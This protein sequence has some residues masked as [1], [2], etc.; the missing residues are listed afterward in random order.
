MATV[1]RVLPWR[2]GPNRSPSIEIAELLEAYREHHPKGDTALI[3]RA[4]ELAAAA[5]EGQTR[6][7][8]EPYIRHP[9]AVATIV[10]RQGI[11]DVTI[12]G[13]L[14]HDAVED[15]PVGLKQLE[16]EFG[17]DLARIVDGVTKL[18]RVKYD[19]KEEQQAATVR[20]M[21]VA[22]ASDMRVLIIKLA[23]RLHNLRTVAALPPF[24]QER[25]ARETLD[26]YAPLAHRLGMQDMK[27]QLEDLSFAALHPRRYAEIDQMIHQ[28]APERD[29]YLAQ[30]LADVQARL[31]ELGIVAEIVGRPKHLWSIYEKM[32]VK[33]RSFD[34]IF[35][36]VG[37]RVIVDS[38]RECYGALG[39][40]HATW[41]PVQGRFKD[42]IAMPKFNLYQSLH[43]T[44][45]GPQGKSIEV[46]IRTR[47]M[48][49][50]AEFGVAAHSDY[51]DGESGGE[52]AWLNRIVEWQ[53]ETA[54]HS[55]F[56][57]N[58]KVDLDQDEVY[59]FTPKGKV[60][61]LPVGATP[62]DFAYSIHTDVGHACI[63]S[64]VNGRLVPL[65][66]RLESGDTVEIFTSKVEG[67]G[68]S[69]DWLKFVASR[70]AANKI[71]QWYT[72]ERREDAIEHGRDE[73]LSA[74]RREGLPAQRVLKEPVLMAVG[75][76]LNYVDDE[77]LFA[78]IGEGH[79][80]GSTVAERIARE[81]RGD[82]AAD[83]HQDR[84]PSN[85]SRRIGAKRRARGTA[86][87]HVE[88]LDDIM[89]R[90]SRCCSP[91]PPDEI[92]GFVTRGRG[93]SVHRSDCLNATTLQEGQPDR[94]IEVEWDADHD[95]RFQTT[96]EVQALDRASLLVDV[97]KVLSDH[98]LNV[99]SVATET[100]DDAVA[101]MQFEFELA[102][103]SQLDAVLSRLL[104]VEAVYDAYRIVPGGGSSEAAD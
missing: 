76:Q 47:E 97:A 34:E 55:E 71:R 54:D 59:V 2:R 33:G 89:I 96:I 53:Q 36:L 77:S 94:L 17:S 104:A 98:G 65:D 32:V 62:V 58:L 13:A 21:I 56:M 3:E 81:L 99:V 74:L 27:Q 102:D 6:K 45:V 101:K 85:V 52:M 86:G 14:L 24:K 7:S 10:A 42:Y 8:G 83:R 31:A 29:L 90:I 1:T 78:A 49:Q 63:G 30:V 93:V 57:S 37:I 87:V 69:R 95:G 44:V 61:E 50:R 28:R 15:T 23:D 20:K 4:F 64:K 75:E 11:D 46:Q 38:V 72:R 39:S 19:T 51:K 68:P 25:T 43:T 18:E 82:D 88:G 70:R 67:A 48:H 79:V 35:D 103:V 41:R 40:I 16:D 5:H 12:A 80:A 92:V 84:L 9:V 73:L 22:I 66:S 100:G 26:V 60:V 91:V